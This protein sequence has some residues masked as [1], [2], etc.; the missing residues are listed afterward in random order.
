MKLARKIGQLLMIGFDGK[1]PPKKILHFIKTYDIGGVIL[2][3][4]NIDDPIQLAQLIQHLQAGSKDAPLFIGIDQ[5]GGR[6]SRLPR[7]F[8]LFP[9]ARTLGQCNSISMTYCA[10]EAMARELAVV[11]I[12]MNFAPV[13]DL[14]TNPDN[15]IIGDRAF[16]KTSPLVAEHGLAMMSGL[17]DNNV[18]ACGK[19]FPGHGDTALDSHKALPVVNHPLSRLMDVEL[20]PFIHLVQ[21]RLTSMM[22][23][24]ILCPMLD[25]KWPATLSKKIVTTLLRKAIGFNGVVVS[26]DLEMKG[27][28]SKWSVAE[29]A[30]LAINAGVDLLLIC[31]THDQQ[32]A[33]LEALIH[34]V[35]TGD[36]S[37]KQ[38]DQSL[39]RVLRLKEQFL[40]GRTRPPDLQKIKKV[41]G[42]PPHHEC[43]AE[44]KKRAA[45][46]VAHAS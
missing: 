29:A 21:N 22:T 32:V 3:A 14:D 36:L 15:P 31:Q 20:K 9:P 45:S 40:L 44:I 39:N 18:I 13:L 7:P 25:R 19:H 41:V 33:A 37:E 30:V 43:V 8:T 4:R 28:T 27:I 5:E 42:S 16:G 11:G 2:F 34:A 35:E 23:A 10:A 17:Q 1:T 26:D 46:H 38:I 6:V 24:H 12:N